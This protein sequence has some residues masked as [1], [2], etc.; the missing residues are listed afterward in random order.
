[1][2]STE[3][4]KSVDEALDRY[5]LVRSTNTPD[6]AGFEDWMRRRLGTVP[7]GAP[8]PLHSGVSSPPLLEELARA[9]KA[10]GLEITRDGAKADPNAKWDFKQSEFLK[11]L[12]KMK[13][14]LS[15]LND[16]SP[17][18]REVLIALSKADLS[19]DS[20]SRTSSQSEHRIAFLHAV[21]NG[22]ELTA[23]KMVGRLRE[24]HDKGE[25]AFLE[26]SASFYSNRF[27]EAIRY[28]L[29]VPNDA[30][31][32]PRAFMLL[33]ESHAYLG[34]FGSIETEINTHP[35]FIFPEYFLRY[36]C[37]VAIENS[38]DPR[39]T[40]ECAKRVVPDELGSL[41]GLGA[42]QMWNRHG[43]Q[44]ATRLLELRRDASL[45]EEAMYQT[46]AEGEPLE[47][48][49]G[50]LLF[51]Q[52]QHALALDGDMVSRLS[53]ATGDDAYHEI[54]KRLMNYAPTRKDYLQA[55][56]TQWRIGDRSVFLNNVLSITDPSDAGEALVRAYEEAM[57]RNRRS[58]M[59]LIRRKL[60]EVPALADKL[61]EIESPNK[62]GLLEG[63]LSP[64]ARIALRSASWD[65][66]Q[67]EKDAFLWKDAG[68]ISLGFFRIL[69]LEFNARLILPILQKL[70]MERLE[71][72]LAA[73]KT[74]PSRA[75][76]AAASFWER[77]LPKLQQ[78]KQPG[79]GL[80]LGA[81]ELLLNK[82]ASP[83]GVDAA[84]K[85]PIHLEILQLLSPTGAEA[86]KSGSL[87]HP[88][89]GHA[90]E[91][92][93]NPPAHSRYVGLSV[94][95]ECKQYVLN[96]LGRLIEYTAGQSGS[97]RTLH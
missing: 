4:P 96:V 83:T 59:E 84:L 28:A 65:L 68:M 20:L 93:R 37:Q 71:I 22:D 8:L 85:M 27:K 75:A 69:E 64:M 16:S 30:I 62:G 3:D 34:D 81:L 7:S 11:W 47:E 61:S 41:S 87:A 67:A 48:L 54:V 82:V 25:V 89:N 5:W 19:A 43:C 80:E 76:K 86:F 40:L 73:L 36:V 39:V 26:A 13:L 66:A 53:K 31:D 78:A 32:W 70:D 6:Y 1:M 10:V 50:S 14:L 42:F 2:N 56:D 52:L 63:E 49:E 77:M 79:R 18:T 46:G 58:D 33:L 91:K 90:R 55:L 35:S 72:G 12:N 60:L 97:A 9:A 51:R 57:S 92:F 95:R 44:L 74:E 88:I 29:E 17:R 15:Y 45:T 21:E 38:P 94:A 23:F 24:A